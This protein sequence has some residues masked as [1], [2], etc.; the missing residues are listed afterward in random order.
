MTFD[1]QKLLRDNIRKLKPYS[2]ARD[3]FS[4]EAAVFL[5]A[6]ENPFNAPYNRYPDPRQMELKRKIAPVKNVPVEKI[7]LGNGSDEP[8]DLLI[9][10]FCSP[11]K[12]NIVAIAPTYGMYRVAAEVN[13]VEIL[14]APLNPDYTLLPDE[15]PPWHLSRF[16][17]PCSSLLSA[18]PLYFPR[19]RRH[20]QQLR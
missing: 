10:A 20:R 18:V 8:I 13:D 9:R 14:E 7:F 5:D 16:R 4:G 12:E 1:I 2:S 19:S 11:G 17:K 6:N 15:R 3:E